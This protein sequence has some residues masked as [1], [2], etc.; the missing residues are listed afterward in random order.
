MTTRGELWNT[1][2]LTVCNHA[3]ELH[4]HATRHRVR[5]TQGRP[6]GVL[7]LGGYPVDTHTDRH[8]VSSFTTRS[9]PAGGG[10][11]RGEGG[12]CWDGA[13]RGWQGHAPRW[14]RG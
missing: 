10:D 3:Q 7:S 11:H 5:H 8:T 9:C 6:H 14:R 13:R 4:M 12:G 1:R 2:V